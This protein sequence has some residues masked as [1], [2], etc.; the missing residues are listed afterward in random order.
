MVKD[1]SDDKMYL[2]DTNII[3]Y[4]INKKVPY[5]NVIKQHMLA[6]ET[7]QLYISTLSI[8]ELY[9][10]HARIRDV[11]ALYKERIKAAIDNLIATLTILE[12][13]GLK[14]AQCSGE[15]MG[16]LIKTGAPIQAIDTMLAGQAMMEN[17][18]LITNDQHF[19]RIEG[20]VTKNWCR[21]P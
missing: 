14:T 17:L 9:A 11:D 1:H 4:L 16:K 2:I 19:D 20:L 5:F 18:I 8:H 13:N 21:H 6:V 7:N 15:I 3:S 10:G 12:Y